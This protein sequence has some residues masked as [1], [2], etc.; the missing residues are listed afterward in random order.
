MD[1]VGDVADEICADVHGTLFGKTGFYFPDEQTL[2]VK[3]RDIL[4]E[5]PR[6]SLVLGAKQQKTPLTVS[7]H[8]YADFPE[9][10]SLDTLGCTNGN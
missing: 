6:A 2:G 9:R 7:G 5:A 3:G 8:L 10:L 4:V 1:L